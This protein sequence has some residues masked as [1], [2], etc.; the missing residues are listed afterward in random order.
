MDWFKMQTVWGASVERLSDAEAGRFVKAL[1]AFIRDGAEFEGSSGR[2]DPITWQALETLRGDVES[3][4]KTE[5]NRIAHEEAIKEKRR[6][7]AKS[8]WQMQNDADASKCMQKDANADDCKICNANASE[9]KNKNLKEDLKENTLTGV[10]EKRKRF[11][12]PTLEEVS[13]YCRERH[14][15]VDPQRFIDYY[16]ARGWELKHGQ[17]VKDWMAC[18][19]T[20]ESQYKVTPM[21]RDKASGWNYEQR[22]YS[23]DELEARCED[24]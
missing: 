7:A 21:T 17:K 23:E 4:K 1:Y 18:I 11:S 8:R 2:E 12:P 10:Q 22:D 3:F 24:I 14:N 9:N 16:E 19:R 5:A 13:A 15:K 6:Q 20:W